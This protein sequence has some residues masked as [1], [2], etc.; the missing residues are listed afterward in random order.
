MTTSAYEISKQDPNFYP[1]RNEDTEHAESI[2]TA[3]INGETITLTIAETDISTVG[4]RLLKNEFGELYIYINSDVSVIAP[5]K[6]A[7]GS[8]INLDW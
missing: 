6:D 2:L 8:N 3:I 7:Y 4:G 1:A 5:I